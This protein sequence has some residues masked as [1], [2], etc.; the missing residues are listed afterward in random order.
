VAT[1]TTPASVTFTFS[2]VVGATS[3]DVKLFDKQNNGKLVGSGSTS[4][5]AKPVT[6]TG[7]QSKTKYYYD[8]TVTVGGLTSDPESGS[9]TT[10]EAGIPPQAPGVSVGTTANSVSFTFVAVAGATTYDVRVLNRQN[11]ALIGSGS[12]NDAGRSVEITGLVSKTSYFYEAA[13][14]VGGLT[15][16]PSR[17]SFTTDADAVPQPSAPAFSTVVTTSSS[18][19][20]TFSPVQGAMSYDVSVYDKQSGGA[21]LRTGATQ[22]AS[23]PVSFTGLQSNTRYFYEASVTTSGGSSPATKGSFQTQSGSGVSD[24][25]RLTSDVPT[26]YWLSNNYPNPFNPS[27][28]I[29]FSIPTSAHVRVHI[30][31]S[32]G[33]QISTLVDGLYSPGRYLVSWEASSFPSG[34]YFYRLQTPGFAA[35]K[36]LMLVK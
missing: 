8:A 18:V 36:R 29:E 7:L 15:S 32:L 9:F 20:F 34:V 28:K 14:T 21:L 31:N 23:R 25:E 33:V 2:Q 17:G 30:Y 1:T 5:A 13:V 12:T 26:S 16:E 3:Y 11:G 6:I 19:S 22:D 35:T 24:V 10:D 27:T 4:D